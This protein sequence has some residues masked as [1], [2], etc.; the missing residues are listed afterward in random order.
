MGQLVDRLLLTPDIHSSNLA[1]GNYNENIEK[2]AW[3]GTIIRFEFKS[4]CLYFFSSNFRPNV[5]KIFFVNTLGLKVFP[6]LSE[7]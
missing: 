4:L 3:N 5:T 7:N 6:H 1:I 2:E